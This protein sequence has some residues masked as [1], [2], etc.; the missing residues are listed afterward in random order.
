MAE[1]IEVNARAYASLSTNDAVLP[2]RIPI[3]TEKGTTL[4]MPAYLKTAQ[5]M[6]VKV[7]SVF[8]DNP[9]L[10]LPRIHALVLVVDTETGVPISLVD[11]ERLTA[12]RTGAGA[13][14]ATKILARE[15][16]RVLALFGAGAQAMDQV[17]AVLSVRNIREVR[18]FTPSGK[19]A[20]EL[21][22][23]IHQQFPHVNAFAAQNPA[24]AI[25]NAD[26]IT[27]VTTS[28]EPVFNP[29][30]VSAGTHINGVGS[31][32]PDMREVP[33]SGYQ[34]SLSI[35]VD[36]LQASLTEAGELMEALDKKLI[37]KQNLTEIGDV[38]AGNKPGR[39]SSDE[40]TF[41]KSV[42]VGVQ[43]AA[44]AQLVLKRAKGL[45]LGRVVEV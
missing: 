14:A 8:N 1:A 20:S 15:D 42:G 31:F 44:T 34:S 23:R 41:F 35:F 30:E 25:R 45:G 10:N 17:A 22:D 18:I 40:I 21:A 29:V 43:D 38:I 16:A 4:F 33:V 3:E 2:Q 12:L 11:G 28:N 39:Q 24:H 37:Q 13:G 7:V 9:K 27:C 19:S 6:A 26:I 32:K 5:A 36:S